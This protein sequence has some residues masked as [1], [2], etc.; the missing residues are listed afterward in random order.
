MKNTFAHRIVPGVLS[1]FLLIYAG[2]Q[3]YR[4]INGQY[5][6]ETVY[7]YTV[8]ESA[9]VTGIALRNEIVL[10]ERIGSGVAAYIPSDGTK[11][12]K[13]SPIAEIYH[14][15]EDAAN[16]QKLR[17]LENQRALLEK[18]QDPGTTSFAHTDVL[19]KQIFSE[20][21][22]VID[23]VNGE[24]LTDLQATSD[25]LLVLMNTKQI[26]TGKQDNFNKAIELIRAEEEYC[27]SRISDES[28]IITAAQPGYFMRNIDGLEGKV[29]FRHLDELTAKDLFDLIN[30]PALKKSSNRV[31]KLMVDHNWYFAAQV[32]A[33][34]IGKYRLGASVTLDFN[35]SGISPIPAVITN[36]NTQ[37]DQT[38]AVVVF[39]CDYVN[40]ALINLRVAQADVKFKSVTG[41][42]VSSSAI[43]FI[44]IQ[45]GVYTVLSEKLVFRP[46]EV[47]Y[48][49]TGF[50]LCRETQAEDPAFKN[51]LQQFDEI[52]IEGTQ[53]Y[54]DKRIK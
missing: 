21:G 3:V 7:T 50:V 27:S 10:D 33:D 19:N 25:K 8:A 45:K 13:G 9:R 20:L 36:I 14:S 16:I 18:A 52:V 29:D 22:N 31:G 15:G 28:T 32:S 23:A 46:V 34:E 42:R 2:F 24:N 48:E 6:T 17:E 37:K 38:D 1:V 54:D 39:R 47:I 44:G 5:K 35:I 49:D 4:Y 41:L 26:A 53:L 51:S 30:A 11:V 12:S 43:R 40:Q